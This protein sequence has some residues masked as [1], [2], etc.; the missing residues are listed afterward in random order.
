MN[1]TNTKTINYPLGKAITL[2]DF[3][4]YYRH[5][6]ELNIIESSV[7][8]STGYSSITC[9]TTNKKKLKEFEEILNKGI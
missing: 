1:T 9:Y 4:Y 3:D 7:Y 8:S 2:S 6:Q 5:A